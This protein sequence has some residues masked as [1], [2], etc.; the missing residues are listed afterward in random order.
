[1]LCSEARGH[2]GT[3]ERFPLIRNVLLTFDR[4]DR[5]VHKAAWDLVA[6]KE[7]KGALGQLDLVVRKGF[8]AAL[9][10]LDLQELKEF[11]GS[12]EA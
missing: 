2:Q 6:P 11:R 7:S 3:N 10:R 1:M 8:K 5:V 4:L 9:G 12:K